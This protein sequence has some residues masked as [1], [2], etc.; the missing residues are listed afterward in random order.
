[1]S[2]WIPSRQTLVRSWILFV[3]IV[4]ASTILMNRTSLLEAVITSFKWSPDDDS[5]PFIRCANL[6]DNY[7]SLALAYR[8]AVKTFSPRFYVK[9]SPHHNLSVSK[10]IIAKDLVISSSIVKLKNVNCLEI[11]KDSQDYIQRVQNATLRAGI[12]MCDSL[13][14][15]LTA[16]CELFQTCRGYIMSPLTEEELLFPLAYS[17]IV[18]RD[19]EMVERLLRAIYR[20]QNYYCI[21]VDAKASTAFFRAI[22]DIANCFTNIFIAS[23]RIDVK[24]GKYSVLQPELLCMEELWRYPRWKY[25]LNLTG[26]EFPLKTN[27][28]L[29]KILKALKGA[30]DVMTTVQ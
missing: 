29:V 30:N 20:P 23:K 5:L 24:W 1:M 19:A 10:S 25:F 8:K 22:S 28:E 12:P 4:A 17:L 9:H 15:T 14:S 18:Y 2:G 13:Y 6:T 3:S 7:D 11:S 16:D 26:Q 27:Y 21:H